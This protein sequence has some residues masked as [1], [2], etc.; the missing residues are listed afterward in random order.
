MKVLVEFFQHHNW[1][2]TIRLSVP[3]GI[4]AV[5]ING[6]TIHSLTGLPHLDGKFNT[7][8]IKGLWNDVHYLIID[9]VSMV[10]AKMMTQISNRI[11][12]ARSFATGDEHAP[13]LGSKGGIQEALG[14]YQTALDEYQR[15]QLLP[16][17]VGPY[18]TNHNPPKDVR[19]HWG[20]FAHTSYTYHDHTGVLR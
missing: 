17:M 8:S 13:V 14:R 2:N 15:R 3:T 19:Q 1:V 10:S 12:S 16:N 5:L 7:E 6:Y 18:P 4:V 9:E 20:Q 11:S